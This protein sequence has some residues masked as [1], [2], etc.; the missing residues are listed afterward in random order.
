MHIVT[1]SDHAGYD[2]KQ[3]LTAFL[4]SEGHTVEDAGT[5]VKERCDYPDYAAKVASAVVSAGRQHRRSPL[6]MLSREDRPRAAS[7]F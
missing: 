7:A 6:P 1:G 5:P 2:L 3:S 4:E